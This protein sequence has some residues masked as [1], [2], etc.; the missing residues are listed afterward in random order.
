MTA[1]A[2]DALR[3]IQRHLEAIY[4]VQAG[5]DVTRFLVG[6]G[7]LDALVES[8]A[9][10]P[11]LRG[12]PEQVLVEDSGDGL[13]V[14]VYLADEVQAGLVKG[15]LQ[16]HCHATEGVSHFLLLLWSGRQERQVRMLDLEIQA[17]VD[18]AST[19]LLLDHTFN[20]GAG[21]RPLL[22]RLFGAFE[23]L[24]GL[25]PDEQ[26]RYR[27][28]HHLG[29]R[30]ADHLAALL[31]GGVDQFLGELRRFYRLPAEGKRERAALAA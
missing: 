18:K 28:A 7:G 22:R 23:P 26:E 29:R 6:T 21:A 20:G 16:A 10:A 27:A 9:A 11:E 19:V 30:Y 3:G 14:A 12:S 4:A 31:E 17:E 15:S 25:H 1:A 2:R 24:P 5:E 13:E 8:G